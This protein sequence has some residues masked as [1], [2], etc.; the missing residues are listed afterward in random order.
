MEISRLLD[1]AILKPEMTR[2][3]VIEAINLGLE[4]N[5]R[6]VCVRPCDI[7]LASNM[8]KGTQ[9]GV[10]TVLSFPHGCEPSQLKKEAAKI[11]IDLGADEI[12]MV[13]N[14]GYIR[15]GL[16]DEVTSDILTVC[17]ITKANGKLL[18]VIFETSTLTPDQITQT[19]I[20]AVNAGA[21]FVKTSTGFN[22]RGASIEDI[23]LMIVAGNNKIG[24]KPSGGIRNYSRAKLFADMGC[25]RLGVNYSSTP[26]ICKGIIDDNTQNSNLY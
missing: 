1:H 18:K 15:S 24:V 5:V 20:C 22:G 12:D 7:A 26:K 11:Y 14:Y 4:Y 3:E 2:D 23:S 16:Y 10:S 6:T 21:D 17:D 25:Q 8:C 13:A 19:T 9:T